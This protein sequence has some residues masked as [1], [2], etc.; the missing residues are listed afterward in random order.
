MAGPEAWAGDWEARLYARVRAR[1]Y[2]SVGEFAYARPTVSVIRLAEE[3][4]PND[5]V[6]VQ[7]ER[8]LIAEASR[9]GGTERLVRDLLTRYLGEVLGAGWPRVLD[10][11]ARFHIASGLARW[12]AALPKEWHDRALRAAQRLF[13]HP[14]PP[15]W[16]PADAHDAF[17]VALIAASDA[18]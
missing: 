6:G 7:V 2:N 10:E 13:A 11:P 15:G 14:P 12:S 3:L 5:V 18:G 4:G 9:T 8:T 17:V 16:K 1:G